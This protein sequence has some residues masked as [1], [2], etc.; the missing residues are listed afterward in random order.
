MY[1]R[2]KFSAD[3]NVDVYQPTLRLFTRLPRIARRLAIGKALHP[4]SKVPSSERTFFSHD[5]TM[6]YGDVA[7]QIP[8]GDVLQLHWI[9]EFLDYTAFFSWLPKNV[10]LVWTLHDMTSFTGGCAYDLGCGRFLQKCGLCPQLGSKRESDLSQEIW[11]RKQRLYSHLEPARAHIVTPSRWMAEKVASSPLLSRFGRSVIPNGL[12][13]EIFQPRN[14][15]S[16]RELS[17]IPPDAKVILFLADDV[18][19]GRKGYHILMETLNGIPRDKK[20]FLLSA[21]GGYPP[22]IP[23]FPHLHFGNI[24]NDRV[25]SFI[26]SAADMFVSPSLMDNLPNTIMESMACGTP[27]VAFE[28]GGIPDLVRPGVNGLLARVGD[29]ADLREAILHLLGSEATR[30]EMSANCRR[31][32]TEEYGLTL[33]ARRYQQLYEGMLSGTNRPC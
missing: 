15:R 20:I 31:I 33:Q 29:A 12:D 23:Q 22:D 32:A 24:V 7:K 10:P 28:A 11:R 1:V 21:G 13:L 27:I 14:P 9:S 26:Y 18:S 25:L 17:G 8:Y 5:R 19:E 30:A 6:F 16:V 2:T 4:H 3:A